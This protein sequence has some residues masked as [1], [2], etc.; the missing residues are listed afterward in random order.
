VRAGAP[1]VYG[2]FTSNVDM[3]SGAPAFGTPEYVKANFGAASS[4]GVW[5]S[6]ALLQCQCLQYRRCPGR[7]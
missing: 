2:S 1:V 3:R 6:L 5:D 7:L 4:R